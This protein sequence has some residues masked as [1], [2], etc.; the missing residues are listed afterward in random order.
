MH[1][2]N[3]TRCFINKTVKLTI[4]HSVCCIVDWSNEGDQA[5]LK[6]DILYM[7][8]KRRSNSILAIA[9]TDVC[10]F[11]E[12]RSA[13]SELDKDNLKELIEEMDENQESP[14]VYEG[15]E[16]I[17]YLSEGLSECSEHVEELKSKSS[18]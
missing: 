10:S 9:Q 15:D 1:F 18:W 2:L 11:D 13:Y 7:L 14:L 17:I 5:S 6:I 3:G 8:T 4:Y 12:L 16:G